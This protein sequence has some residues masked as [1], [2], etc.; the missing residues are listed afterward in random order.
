MWKPLIIQSN[1]AQVKKWFRG[2]RC[3]LPYR[4]EVCPGDSEWNQYPRPLA[5]RADRGI[6]QFEHTADEIV[7]LLKETENENS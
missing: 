5:R 2:L 1:S 6:M 3:S 7:G 4:H